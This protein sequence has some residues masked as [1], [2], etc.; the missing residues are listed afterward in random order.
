MKELEEFITKNRAA[1]DSEAP[2]LDLWDKIDAQ[3]PKQPSRIR[4]LIWT[5]T[6]IAALFVLIFGLGIFTGSFLE[7]EK[8]KT[9]LLENSPEYQEIELFYSQQVNQKVKELKSFK[10]GKDISKELAE[11]ELAFEEWKTELGEDA[12]DEEV[13]AIMVRNFRLKLEILEQL[14]KQLE[15]D[16]S[17]S[18]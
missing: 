3:L 5:V 13:F 14:Q 15:E 17:T 10:K 2:S 7:K 11:L 1:F 18:M 8:S 4:P 9:A 12:T 6:K 16:A